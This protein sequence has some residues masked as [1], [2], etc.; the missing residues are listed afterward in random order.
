MEASPSLKTKVHYPDSNGQ[1]M[2]DNTIQYE[3]IVTLKGNLELLFADDP[4]VFVA[5]DL[6]WYPV[7]NRPDIRQAPDTLV[8]FGRPKGHRG[9]IQAVG[10][11]Q[12][13]APGG[14]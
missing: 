13:P 7:E 1:P 9:S 2:A 3:Y 5:G 6:L 14:L 4:N 11:R 10:R 8:V 12:Y